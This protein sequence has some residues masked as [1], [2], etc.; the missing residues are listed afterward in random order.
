MPGGNSSNPAA[1]ARSLANLK[2]G[3]QGMP[4]NRNRV[5]HGAYARIAEDRLEVKAREVYLALAEDAPVRAGDGGL[6]AADAVPV[7]LLAETLCRL[8]DVAAYLRDRGLL[9]EDGNLRP[10]VDVERRLRAE[11]LDYSEA[12]GMTPRSRARLGL[13]LARSFDLAA[14]WAQEPGVV[15]GQVAEGVLDA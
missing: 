4:G 9:G 8:D 14:M 15:D 2:R 6:P 11:A 3:D 12:L 13:D 10:A 5:T 7:R 1:R